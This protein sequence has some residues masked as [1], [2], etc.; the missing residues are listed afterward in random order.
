MATRRLKWTLNGEDLESLRSN[1]PRSHSNPPRSRSNPP[2]PRSVPPRT[3]SLPPVGSVR[4]LT[5]E[6]MGIAFQPIVNLTHGGLFAVEALARP[7]RPEFPNPGVLFDAAVRESATGRL[8]RIIRE[9]TFGSCPSIPVFVNIHPSEL[10]SR[11]LVR[12]DDPLSFHDA[13][14]YLEVTE[15]AA[16]EYFD[17]CMNVLKDV[18]TRTGSFLVIDDLG[19]GHS[20]LKRVLDLEPRIVKLDIALVAGIDKSKRQQTLVRHLVQLFD[21]LGAKVVGE[22]IETLDEL[23]ALR[24]T[25]AQFGQGFLLARPGNPVPPVVWPLDQGLVQEQPRRRPR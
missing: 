12:P 1:A 2:R 22:G 19:A 13:A 9:V 24:D 18:C 7:R 17:L 3:R 16:F 15:A 4:S 14:V 5:I 8:G 21:E 23:K 20:N 11:W 25:G 10:T 6:D